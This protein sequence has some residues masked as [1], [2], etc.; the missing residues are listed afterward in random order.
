MGEADKGEGTMASH[1]FSLKTLAAWLEKQPPGTQYD[2][3]QLRGCLLTRFVEGTGGRAV[4]GKAYVFGSRWLPWRKRSYPMTRTP[5]MSAE[6]WLMHRIVNESG[7]YGE[8]LEA[9]R[10]ALAKAA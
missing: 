8:A 4:F 1:E 6:H 2:Y 7:T 3:G 10:A 9:I 5:D